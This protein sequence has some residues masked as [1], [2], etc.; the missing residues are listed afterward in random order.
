LRGRDT[1]R[2]AAAPAACM[3]SF[4]EKA[5]RWVAFKTPGVADRYLSQAVPSVSWRKAGKAWQ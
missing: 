4:A 2:A 3:D 1:F 5:V